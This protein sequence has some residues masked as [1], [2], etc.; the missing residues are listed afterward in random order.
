[1]RAAFGSQLAC[2]IEWAVHECAM[3]DLLN[4]K[5]PRYI[6][7]R[8]DDAVWADE[9]VA[10]R[11]EVLIQPAGSFGRRLMA[12]DAQ[13]LSRRV[14]RRLYLGA[15]APAMNPVCLDV[16]ATALGRGRCVVGATAD[17]RPALL[18]TTRGWPELDQLPF[19]R[20]TSASRIAGC[21]RK[22]GY[23]L[24]FVNPGVTVRCAADIEICNREIEGDRRPA[25]A[26]LQFLLAALGTGLAGGRQLIHEVS[27][28]R[29][30][31]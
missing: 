16:A 23:E 11:A 17:G 19:D 26:R 5:G 25:R 18:G 31:A 6:A 28:G 8:A 21:C 22:A 27:P 7:V 1:L 13:L 20:A 4:W 2:L 15:A 30:F 14:A 10:D 9:A 24:A 3:E 29:I 12:L